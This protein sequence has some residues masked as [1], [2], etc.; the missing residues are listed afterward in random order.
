MERKYIQYRSLIGATQ[1]LDSLIYYT[2]MCILFCI[3]LHSNYTNNYLKLSLL[4]TVHIIIEMI[5]III[6]CYYISHIV[7]YC[8]ILLLL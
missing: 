7:S 3:F 6:L 1:R 4:N 5:I 8:I 2:I